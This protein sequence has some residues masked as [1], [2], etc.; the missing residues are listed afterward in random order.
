MRCHNRS[1]FVVLLS[2][3]LWCCGTFE[4]GRAGSIL[5]ESF[6]PQF[7][8]A[9]SLF[10][11]RV[12][13]TRDGK[14]LVGGKFNRVNGQPYNA[15]VRLNLDGS[16]DETFDI[17][18]GF[19]AIGPG[20]V[21]NVVEQADG[22]IL[23]GGIFD[24]FNDQPENSIVRLNVDG[25]RD[26]SFDVGAG[27]LDYISGGW[28]ISEIALQADGKILV[29]GPFERWDD[30]PHGG[31]VRLNEDGGVDESFRFDFEPTVDE[32]ISFSS[33]QV[34]DDQRILA[35]GGGSAPIRV[36]G[37]EQNG[38]FILHPNGELDESFS[39]GKGA[40][41]AIIDATMLSGGKVLIGGDFTLFNEVPL[42][43]MALLNSDGS[44]DSSFVS[45]PF[46]TLPHL[47]GD[48]PAVIGSPLVQS[49]GKVLVAGVFSEID[50]VS[51][52]SLA[53]LDSDGSLDQ[54]FD[55]G[56]GA[57][58][59]DNP[60]QPGI[61]FNLNRQTDG[62][63]LAFG[64]FDTY[65]GV[66]QRGLVRLVADDGPPI[67]SSSIDTLSLNEQGQIELT[68]TKND[69]SPAIVEVTETFDTWFEF[70]R[71]EEGPGT[72]KILD[73]HI[74]GIDARYYRLKGE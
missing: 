14:L 17:G 15:L 18:S 38:L 74:A 25:S 33:L 9:E 8:S 7:E 22:R 43:Q 49:D 48:I 52:G 12:I 55:P 44:L 32:Q 73:E 56:S 59:D 62:R 16:V 69:T 58:T 20:R 53:R 70:A 39:I 37:I 2:L 47:A 29:G 30:H 36:N 35:V 5:D 26:D 4:H 19:P 57:L 71:F 21:R 6:R 72:Y 24:Q 31:L 3:V 51:R 66:R 41:G 27:P 11:F 23:V 46:L 67:L 13:E 40:D 45:P 1:L 65:D 63:L 54:A 61:L 64:Y 42:N 50:G 10:I 60:P 28:R 68:I 34:L